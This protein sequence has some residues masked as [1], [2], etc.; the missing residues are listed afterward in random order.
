MTIDYLK[1][2]PT[3]P[4]RQDS[5]SEQLADLIAI[6][7]RLGLHDAADSIRQLYK[8]EVPEPVK[9]GCHVNLEEVD[10]P[11]DDCVID[12]HGPHEC[13]YAKPGMK[14]EECSYWK[15]IKRKP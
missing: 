4:Q 10:G 12:T 7:N 6:A 1:S 2:L 8:P 13:F 15:I 11:L 9:Y 5:V 14:K 3:F